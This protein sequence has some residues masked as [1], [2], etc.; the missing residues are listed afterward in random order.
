MQWILDNYM[1]I[2][3][4]L[5]TLLSVIIAILKH[6]GKKKTADAL[7]KIKDILHQTFGNVEALKV[8]WKKSGMEAKYGKIGEIFASINEEAKLEDVLKIAYNQWQADREENWKPVN[9]KPKE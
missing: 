6:F 7:G 3:F 5:T 2:I 1:A 8:Q 9:I 4:L